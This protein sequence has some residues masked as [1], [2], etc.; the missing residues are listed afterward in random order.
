[1]AIP[2]VPVQT[3]QNCSNCGSNNLLFGHEILNLGTQPSEDDLLHEF[4]GY[5]APVHRNLREWLKERKQSNMLLP[6]LA[7]VA[8]P[9]FAYFQIWAMALMCCIGALIGI[10]QERD[11]AFRDGVFCGTRNGVVLTNLGCMVFCRA[12]S[13]VQV[14]Y[15]DVSIEANAENVEKLAEHA[16]FEFF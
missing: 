16:T 1:M 12:C 7:I 4:Y 11:G 5:V 6:I 15:A 13:H 14:A 8:A 2:T 10:Y 9:V 3:P